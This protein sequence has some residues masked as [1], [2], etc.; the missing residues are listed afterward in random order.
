M[1]DPLST[2]PASGLV[3]QGAKDVNIVN[4]QQALGQD[5]FLELLITQLTNQ[6]P[7]EPVKDTEFIAQMASFSALEQQNALNQ[8]MTDYVNFQKQNTV[9]MYLGNEVTVNTETGPVVG[10][11]EAVK[12]SGDSAKLV[13][14]GFEYDA[15]FVEKVSVPPVD[16]ENE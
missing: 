9:Q 10:L 16:K 14:N 7:L 12:T 11:V 5:E 8:T 15:S 3:A 13:I 4:G 2:T 6:D 1:I